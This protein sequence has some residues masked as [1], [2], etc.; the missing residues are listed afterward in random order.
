M[1]TIL[2]ALRLLAMVVWVGGIVFFAFVLAPVAFH[3]LPSVHE[4]GT[5][6]G[7]TLRVFDGIAL[8]CG[9]AFAIA[10][11]AL[12]RG[13]F[14]RGYDGQILLAIAMLLATAYL[15]FSILPA[16]DRDRAQAGGSI[17]AASP[18]SAPRI[19]FDRLHQ[20]SEQVEGGVLLLGLAVIVLMACEPKS[21][22]P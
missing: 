13:S 20:M 5:V 2:R 1:G 12:R 15:H 4:A 22:R 10:T 14:P 16:M 19:H 21:L 8:V 7:S 11:A 18:A 17:E 3:V 9:M 6:V